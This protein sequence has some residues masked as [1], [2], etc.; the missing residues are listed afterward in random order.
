MNMRKMCFG[1]LFSL[2]VAAVASGA[3]AQ[4][5]QNSTPNP[6][7]QPAGPDGEVAPMG[8]IDCFAVRETRRAESLLASQPGTP[9]E[10]SAMEGL[11]GRRSACRGELSAEQIADLT[12]E[13]RYLRGIIAQA[14]YLARYPDAAPASIASAPPSEIAVEIYNQRVTSAADAP[15]E[16]IRIFGDCMAAADPMRLDAL[17]R[18]DAGSAQETTAIGAIQPLMG[19]C[20]W[21]GQSVQ[22]TRT[23]LRAALADALYRKAIAP[24]V[25]A[26]QVR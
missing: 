5:Y 18:S 10:S 9:A 2:S 17:V 13:P 8:L 22:F 12:A 26:E 11:T 23:T 6:T 21:N 15:S 24:P 19:P 3:G 4:G 14:R 7:P 16:I 1:M 20:L 25:V